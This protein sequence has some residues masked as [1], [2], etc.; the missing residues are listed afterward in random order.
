MCG[1]V[2][3][4]SRTDRDNTWYL[5]AAAGCWTALGD[6]TA[7]RNWFTASSSARA[8]SATCLLRHD[9]VPVYCRIDSASEEYRDVFPPNIRWIESSDGNVAAAGALATPV[10]V[11]PVARV[12]SGA[13]VLTLAAMGTDEVAA[14][15]RPTTEDV[16]GKFVLEATRVR[17]WRALATAVIRDTTAG[18][19]DIFE[20]WVSTRFAFESRV[21]TPTARGGG[22]G[23]GERW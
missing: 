12:L 21:G 19:C 8:R 1:G 2:V 4:Y 20:W 23:G 10:A 17:L 16:S 3:K 14:A 9:G 15:T 5:E 11:G 18:A 6:P 22:G 13:G 7:V